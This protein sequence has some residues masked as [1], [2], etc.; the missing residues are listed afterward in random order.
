MFQRPDAIAILND[1]LA[2][3]SLARYFAVMQNRKLTTL[4]IKKVMDMVE[5]AKDTLLNK[6]NTNVK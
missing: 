6:L 3:K 4:N 2:K 5:K 1:K